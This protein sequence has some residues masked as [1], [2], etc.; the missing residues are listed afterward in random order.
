MAAFLLGFL[1]GAALG[2]L[3][4]LASYVLVRRAQGRDQSAFLRLVF[5]GLMVRMAAVVTAVL[6]L[7]LLTPVHPGGFVAGL[8]ASFVAGTLFEG[9]SLLHRPPVAPAAD[10]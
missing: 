3:N 1:M 10:A 2:T 6:L 9:A 4:A 8:L 5:G 7:L